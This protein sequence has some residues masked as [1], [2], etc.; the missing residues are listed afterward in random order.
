MKFLL[1]SYVYNNVNATS[2]RIWPNCDLAFGIIMICSRTWPNTGSFFLFDWNL[3][4]DI[5]ACFLVFLGT[6]LV[7]HILT[8]RNLVGG[9]MFLRN[10]FAFGNFNVFAQFF[11]HVFAFFLANIFAFFSRDFLTVFLAGVGGFAFLFFLNMTF[12]FIVMGTFLLL[13]SGTFLFV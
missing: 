11:G 9:A 7:W 2:N 5:L 13:F 3:M 1:K 6:F 8:F 10:I 4:G 12:F